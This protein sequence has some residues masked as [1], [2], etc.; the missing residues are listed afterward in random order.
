MI[1]E[2]VL[3]L[4]TDEKLL[5]AVRLASQHR[6]NAE[7]LLEQRVSFVYGSLGKS[8]AGMTKDHVRQVILEQQGGVLHK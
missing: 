8:T 2:G 3:N 4:K 6:L 5:T 1:L 7:E